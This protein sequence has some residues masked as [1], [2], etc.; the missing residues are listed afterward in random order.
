MKQLL[1]IALFLFSLTSCNNDKEYNENAKKTSDLILE[2]ASRCDILSEGYKSVWSSTLT[3]GFY[4]DKY[5]SDSSSAI[6]ALRSEIDSLGFIK[7]VDRNISEIDSLMNLLAKPS[8]NTKATYEE[9]LDMYSNLKQYYS[10]IDNPKG[11]LLTYSKQCQ[12]ISESIKGNSEKVNIRTK[13][14]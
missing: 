2:T 10:L 12:D 11:S 6:Y 7:E 3:G 5:Y 1:F 8:D 13:S 14:N 4:R 9:V